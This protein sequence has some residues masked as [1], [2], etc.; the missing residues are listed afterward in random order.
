MFE[1]YKSETKYVFFIDF[2]FS[3]QV[4]IAFISSFH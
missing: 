4:F 1:G 2:I 3:H